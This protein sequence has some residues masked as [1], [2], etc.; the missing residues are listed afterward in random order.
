M[1]DVIKTIFMA[2]GVVINLIG[3]LAMG[4]DKY[5]AKTGRMRIRERTL[6]AIAFTGGAFGSIIGMAMF[7]HKTRH[8]KYSIGMPLIFVLNAAMAL[9]FRLLLCK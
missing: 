3:F 1:P 2:Y 6:F 9:I 4:L 7:H 5:Y 8:R